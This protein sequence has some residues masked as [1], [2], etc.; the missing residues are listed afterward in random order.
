M[1]KVD[2][3]LLTVICLSWLNTRDRVSG[4]RLLRGTAGAET[5][6]GKILSL[7]GPYGFD[8]NGCTAS[9]LYGNVYG[10]GNFALQSRGRQLRAQRIT[11]KAYAASQVQFAGPRR[12]T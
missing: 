5:L 11:T 10:N 7:T 6:Q 12:P 1:M 2:A 8:D 3:Q 4:V 9:R